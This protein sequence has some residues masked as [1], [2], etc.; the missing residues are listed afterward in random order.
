MTLFMTDDPAYVDW[1]VRLREEMA[2]HSERM[3][4][5]GGAFID[6]SIPYRLGWSPRRAAFALLCI[7][8]KDRLHLTKLSLGLQ[9]HASHSQET[10]HTPQPQPQPQPEDADHLDTSADH[11]GASDAQGV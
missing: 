1:C 7:D 5:S 2:E 3:A 4:R 8:M 11:G 10:N 6:S 9:N